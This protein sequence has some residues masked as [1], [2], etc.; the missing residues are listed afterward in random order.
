MSKCG[1]LLED[2]RRNPRGLR[3]Q[4]VLDLAECWGFRHRK[5][6]GGTSHRIYK[7]DGFMRMLN[8]QPDRNGMAKAPQVRQLLT[9][10]DEL[11]DQG[12][13]EK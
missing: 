7:R 8:F 12:E 13:S 4:E 10:I 5:S 9:A 2:A 1:G 6:G 11:I 3:F